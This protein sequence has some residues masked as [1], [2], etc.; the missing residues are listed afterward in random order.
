MRTGGLGKV[1]NNSVGPYIVL[2]TIDILIS[3]VYASLFYKAYFRFCSVKQIEDGDVKGDRAGDGRTTFKTLNKVL[4]SYCDG[5]LL[6]RTKE[7]CQPDN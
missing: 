2:A 7:T 5:V 4:C 3:V 6:K 1:A